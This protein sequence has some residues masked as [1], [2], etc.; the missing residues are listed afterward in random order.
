M[1]IEIPDDLHET[2]F[3]FLDVSQAAFTEEDV[4]KLTDIEK[5][6]FAFIENLLGEDRV[7]RFK[8]RKDL[9]EAKNAFLAQ[10]KANANQET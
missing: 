10:S 7:Q 4:E 9:N 1:Q 6:L 2:F 8:T 5:R 3:Q